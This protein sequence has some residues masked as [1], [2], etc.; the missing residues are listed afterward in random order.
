MRQILSLKQGTCTNFSEY[1]ITF[2]YTVT[3]NLA[4]K[5]NTISGI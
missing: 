3:V 2:T 4:Y 1:E 5:N